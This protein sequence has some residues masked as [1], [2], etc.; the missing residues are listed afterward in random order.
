MC[1]L[2]KFAQKLCNTTL[3][4][5]LGSSKNLWKATVR[6]CPCLHSTE[7]RELLLKKLTV[8]NEVSF[9]NYTFNHVHDLNVD[10]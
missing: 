7:S 10:F 3:K 4:F 8:I 1:F 5:A 6:A 9:R 2:T